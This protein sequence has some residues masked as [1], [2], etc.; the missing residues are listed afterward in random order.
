MTS[1]DWASL[2]AVAGALVLAGSALRAHRIGARKVVILALAWL[3][4]FAVVA[5]VFATAGR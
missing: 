1:S 3:A 5:A 2:I 4:I